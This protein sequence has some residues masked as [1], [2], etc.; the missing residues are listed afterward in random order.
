MNPL[1]R[2]INSNQLLELGR[3]YCN[4]VLRSGE[5]TVQLFDLAHQRWVWCPKKGAYVVMHKT[6]IPTVKHCGGS[7]ILSGGFASGHAGAVDNVR[8][9]INFTDRKPEA[10][11]L[12]HKKKNEAQTRSQRDLS[13]RRYSWARLRINQEMLMTDRR[14]AVLRWPSSV[15]RPEPD[16]KSAVWSEEGSPPAQPKGPEGRGK[17]LY[18]GMAKDLPIWSPNNKT[19]EETTQ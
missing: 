16:L 3:H 10:W 14:V 1:L 19:L 5:T 17:I 2:E 12:A 13:A 15:S 8:V 18:G 6:V 7:L 11:R 9:T 4:Q